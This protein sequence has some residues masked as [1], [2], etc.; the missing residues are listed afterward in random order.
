MAK[1]T[2]D[3]L[4]STV[5]M[6]LIAP[7]AVY[8]DGEKVAEYATLEDASKHLQTLARAYMRTANAD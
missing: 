6:D 8:V 7:F 5:G 1:E 4:R 3:A 2:F